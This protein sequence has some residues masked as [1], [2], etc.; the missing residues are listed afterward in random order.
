MRDI[1]RSVLQSAIGSGGH[2]P[3]K[4]T[5]ITLKTSVAEATRV[6][7]LLDLTVSAVV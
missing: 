5:A 4:G 2:D 6:N 1:G 3:A 7:S